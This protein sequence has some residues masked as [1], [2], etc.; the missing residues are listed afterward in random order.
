M[1]FEPGDVVFLKSGGSPMTVA[2]VGGDSVDCLWL[3]EE[4][5]LFREAIPTVAL[6]IAADSAD[7]E[8]HDED[9][10]DK[11]ARDE[12]DLEQ[13]D[14]DEVKPAKSKRKTG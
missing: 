7:E 11:S 5:D 2:A 1:A 12:A 10:E 4:G 6:M 13:A 3:G 9:D 8:D 14:D